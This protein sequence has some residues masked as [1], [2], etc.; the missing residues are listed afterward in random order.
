MLLS[1]FLTVS[2]AI[3]PKVIIKSYPAKAKNCK[4]DVFITRSPDKKYE[5][6][7]LIG[8]STINRIKEEACLLGGDGI[9][10]KSFPNHVA[11]VVIKYIK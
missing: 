4:L 5:E 2:C 9:I 11:L 3:L 6:V 8:D 1:F 10:Y 7:A